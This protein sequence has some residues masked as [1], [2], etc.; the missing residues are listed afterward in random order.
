MAQMAQKEMGEGN[1]KP[2]P[3]C[4]KRSRK[5]CFTLNNWTDIEFKSIVNYCKDKQYIIGKEVGTNGTAHLQ[6]YIECK[7]PIAFT[8][9]KKDLGRSHIEAAKGNKRANYIYCSKEKNFVTN[10]TDITLPEVIKDPMDGKIAKAW[11]QEIIDLVKT[12]AN[13][14]TIHWYW[15]DT[16]NVGK[17]SL[18]KHLCMKYNCLIVSGKQNDMFNSIIEWKKNHENYPKIIII[19]IPR[20]NID[21][22][23][24]GGIEKIKDGLFYSGKYEGGMVVM[25]CPHVIC[26]AN[27]EPD[28]NK[29]S[30]DRWN[31]KEIE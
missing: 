22:I 11:Q 20:S 6:G 18:S 15:E 3:K 24:W 2:L 27:S 30:E 1:T 31:I 5:F 12:E 25:N 17:T 16:G 14:R 8:A 29:L 7:N 26:L 9:I 28:R 10:I 21:Y 13:E 23:S 19:D 4:I